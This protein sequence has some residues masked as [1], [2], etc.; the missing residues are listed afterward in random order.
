MVRE[1]K[2]SPIKKIKK[3]KT[4]TLIDTPKKTIEQPIV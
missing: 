1:K 3:L 2:L 4:E